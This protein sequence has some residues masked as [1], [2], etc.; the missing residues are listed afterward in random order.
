MRLTR[1]VYLVGGGAT[2]GFGLSDDPDCHVYLIDGGDHYALIDCGLA[3]G[4]SLDRITENIVREGLDLS[5]LKT[6]ILTHYHM[7]HA[8]GAAKIRERFGL[9]VWA[10]R[11]AAEVLRTA[12]EQ[13]VALD[14]AKQAGMYPA[15]YRFEPVA[16]DRE[17]DEGDV[18]RV[19]DLELRT[20]ATPGHCN[21]HV[22][23]L[24]QGAE[25]RY[26]FAGDAVFAGGRVVWQNIHDCSVP[27]TVASI[28]KLRDVEF[29]ALLP[30]HAAVILDDGKRHVAFAAEQCDK[31]A[32]PKNLTS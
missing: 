23:Y 11:E 15:D 30:G 6:L 12:D 4:A 26:L 27:L 17:L 18:L 21:G 8:G 13:A 7:D 5:K 24:M 9:E 2:F 31:L 20:I 14:V 29:D 19:G 16:V 32:L 1:E 3:D 22:S 25:R 10:P 28:R